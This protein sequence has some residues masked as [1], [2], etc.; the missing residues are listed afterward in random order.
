MIY[1][2]E[3]VSLKVILRAVFLGKLS[4][5]SGSYVYDLHDIPYILSWNYSLSRA[6]NLSYGILWM[7][8]GKF[9]FNRFIDVFLNKRAL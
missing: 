1:Y 7:F 6:P 3:C 8:V 9:G 2:H 5:D 4:P